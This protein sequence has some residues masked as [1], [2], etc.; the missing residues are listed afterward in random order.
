MCMASWER[1]WFLLWHTEGRRA[2]W[3]C[4]EYHGTHFYPQS[5]SEADPGPFTLL[6]TALG[7]NVNFPNING[8]LHLMGSRYVLL[9][10]TWPV[11][12]DS[13]VSGTPYGPD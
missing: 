1:I 11:L 8:K 13:N 6:S 3:F 12:I 5:V 7:L 9:A 2:R 4:R 10:L